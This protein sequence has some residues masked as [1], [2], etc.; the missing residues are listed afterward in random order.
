MDDKIYRKHKLK[1]EHVILHSIIQFSIGGNI[2][3]EE[4]GEC[5]EQDD[6]GVPPIVWQA[7]MVDDQVVD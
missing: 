7:V 1:T 5:T 6:E 3:V 4:G 2:C